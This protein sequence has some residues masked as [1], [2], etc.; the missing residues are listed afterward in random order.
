[1]KC[2]INCLGCES[3]DPEEQRCLSSLIMD[4]SRAREILTNSMIKGIED[5]AYKEYVTLDNDFTADE[6][7]AIA[8]WMRNKGE[9]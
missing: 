5:R 3:G 4:E 1:M 7:E 9:K 8:W 6:L 2:A